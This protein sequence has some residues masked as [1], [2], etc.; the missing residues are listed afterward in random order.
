MAHSNQMRE[1]QLS[2]QGVR[3]EDVYVGPGEVLT[4]AARLLQEARDEARI[5]AE[6]LAAQQRERDLQQE[7]AGL[8]V[9]S[10]AVAKRL[11][12]IESELSLARKRDAERRQATTKERGELA[13][14]RK[15]DEK[16]N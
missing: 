15:A 13:R 14:A 12:G 2:D 4:G 11:E 6:Q 16:G 7:Q 1:F 10:D 3:L 9:Q 5:L 8:R